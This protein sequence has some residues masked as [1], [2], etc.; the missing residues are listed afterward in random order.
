MII[1]NG[2]IEIFFTASF[3]GCAVAIEKS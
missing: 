1:L 3:S 2:L